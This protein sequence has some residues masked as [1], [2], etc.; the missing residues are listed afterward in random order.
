MSGGGADPVAA[1][2]WLKGKLSANKTALEGFLES[3][4]DLR[5]DLLDSFFPYQSGPLPA[6][7]DGI[8]SL[9]LLHWAKTTVPGFS[10]L[11][12]VIAR[13][14]RNSQPVPEV[15]RDLHAGILDET[16]IAPAG[17]KGRPV[18]N[19]RRDEL[20]LLLVTK[21]Q[22]KFSL[23]RLANY[24]NR[25]GKSAIEMVTHELKAASLIVTFPE[26]DS[27][28]TALLRI[29]AARPADPIIGTIDRQ[30]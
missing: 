5:E 22:V 29:E 25:S 26:L 1:R 10:F 27:I 30:T 16:V 17:K 4:V 13:M 6:Q 9:L 11:R 15:W 24:T 23:P 8:A 19:E 18:A 7:L 28:E 2:V 20:V 14:V 3:R 21:L 12:K